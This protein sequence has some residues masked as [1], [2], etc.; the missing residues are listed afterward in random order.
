M[1]RRIT[2]PALALLL[3]LPSAPARADEGD[4]S[5]M[6]LIGGGLML[7]S[8]TAFCFIDPPD[9][10]DL[11]SSKRFYAGLG[12][13]YVRDNFQTKGGG[14]PY[15]IGGGQTSGGG[16]AGR[17]FARRNEDENQ[18]SDFDQI[19]PRPPE[20]VPIPGRPSGQFDRPEP[21][22]Q[23]IA[24][25]GRPRAIFGN[26]P[27]GNGIFG[28]SRPDAEDGFLPPA[29]GD[30]FAFGADAVLSLEVE[31]G[32]V[33]GIGGRAG[34]R[35]HPR[36]AMEAH[37]EWLGEDFDLSFDTAG[38]ERSFPL[39]AFNG[40]TE[41]HW[42][43]AS[44][45]AE[46]WTIGANARFFLTK[47]RIQ[48]YVLGGL[49]I[50]RLSES[51]VRYDVAI[52]DPTATDR[53]PQVIT[54]PRLTPTPGG[55]AS[56]DPNSLYPSAN[57]RYQSPTVRDSDQFKDIDLVARFG[58]GVEVHV[59]DFM[60][61]NVEGSYVRPTGRIEGYDFYSMTAG[62]MIHFGRNALAGSGD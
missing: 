50:G 30:G 36:T 62:V 29:R 5:F 59:T 47:G 22:G 19:D 54:P 44:T 20:D 43:H 35:C 46:L 53:C 2:A 12:M 28:E 31:D 49:G 16:L 41:M 17:R 3:L 60:S 14:S 18:P 26:P 1:L 61:L 56:T 52:T 39:D 45:D 13:T 38:L 23:E 58:G 24:A 25:D 9:E 10:P 11:Y 55:D 33:W 27:I 40:K 8:S 51:T 21:I 34:Y 4:I 42:R 6:T 7:L 32:A 37:F 15:D 57:C 48:P